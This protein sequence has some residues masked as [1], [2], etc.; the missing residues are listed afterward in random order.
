MNVRFSAGVRVRGRPPFPSLLSAA[1]FNVFPSLLPIVCRVESRKDLLLIQLFLIGSLMIHPG[2]SS[3]FQFSFRR[4]REPALRN[5]YRLF[6]SHAPF[7][8]FFPVDDGLADYAPVPQT[9]F[10][11]FLT[12]L[13]CAD[14]A[15][16]LP[17]LLL[18]R[19]SLCFHRVNLLGYPSTSGLARTRFFD[20]GFPAE[21]ERPLSFRSPFATNPSPMP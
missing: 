14:E 21:S 15:E 13:G 18:H 1:I 16:L 8:L 6:T 2:V 10:P 5:T 4:D 11:L 20:F 9:L 3:C 19:L 17:F 7:V 12:V